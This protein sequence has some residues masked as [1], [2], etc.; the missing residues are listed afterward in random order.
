[1]VEV[2]AEIVIIVFGFILV[3]GLMIES[4]MRMNGTVLEVQE[5]LDLL[6]RGLEVVGT[7]LTRIP[8]LVPQ[9]SINQSPLGQILEFFQ[10]MNAPPPGEDGSYATPELRD[11]VGRFSDGQTEEATPV[12]P[13]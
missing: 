7:V 10:G 2:T 1:M 5:Q 3:L 11:D 6:E 13:E 4:R 9:F 12:E 8:D